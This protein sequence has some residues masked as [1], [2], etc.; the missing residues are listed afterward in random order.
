MQKGGREEHLKEIKIRG[1]TGV[2]DLKKRERKQKRGKVSQKYREVRIV[3]KMV[4]ITKPI[5]EGIM[6]S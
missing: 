3:R 6:Q 1:I 5:F 2:W 4:K